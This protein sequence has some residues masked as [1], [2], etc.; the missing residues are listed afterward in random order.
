MGIVLQYISAGVHKST[1]CRELRRNKGLRGYRPK[2]AHRLACSRQSSISRTRISE[3]RWA[4]IGNMLREDWS[5]EQISGYL[6]ANNKPGVSPEWIYQHIYTDK[7]N[8][9]LFTGT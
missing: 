8:G 5:P 1:I 4:Q 3:A 7:R 9:A 2:Q 6:Q